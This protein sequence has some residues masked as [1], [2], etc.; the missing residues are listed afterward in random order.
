MK[1]TP[2]P[3]YAVEYAGAFIIQDGE[4]YGDTDLHRLDDC[5]EAEA[6]AKLMASAPELLECL[7]MVSNLNNAAREHISDDFFNKVD[8]AIKKATE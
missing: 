4:F 1:H 3:W 2:G 5:E 7:I 6:N 8:Q